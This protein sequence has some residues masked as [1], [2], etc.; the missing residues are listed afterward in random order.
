MGNKHRPFYRIVVSKAD[1]GRDGAAIEYI[2]SYNPLTK[3]STVELKADRALHWLL[4]G[5]QPTET[6]AVLL[7]RQGVLDE[8]FSQRPNAQKKFKFLDKTTKAM[9]QQ[10]VIDT[11]AAPEAAAPAETTAQAEQPS[12]QAN[13]E[14]QDLTPAE[15]TAP[16][17]SS[18]EAP[19]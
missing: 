17:K 3:P 15:N 12:A 7:K 5:A 11:P 13:V 4:T 19:N 18:E 10:S 6:V 1:S 14:S 9:S 8:F 2:G 16:E